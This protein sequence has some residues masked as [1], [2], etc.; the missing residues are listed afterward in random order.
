MNETIDMA[1]VSV[2]LAMP[3]HRG[4]EPGTLRPI[5]LTTCALKDRGIPF[6]VFMPAGG[7][8]V[9]HSR[10][11][12]VHDF[13]QS[14]RNRIFWVDSD[15]V[16]D[17]D[18]FIR[19]LAL[20]VEMEV[21]CGAYPAKREP[22]NFA[23]GPGTGHVVEANKYGC[24]PVNGVGI[25]FTCIQRHVIEQLADRAPKLKYPELDEPVAEVFRCDRVMYEPCDP[26]RKQGF[27][28]EVRGEDM[29]FFADILDLG[30]KIYLDPSI[31]LG[32]VGSK[33]YEGSIGQFL[34]AMTD[35]A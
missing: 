20:S 27:E 11:I 19:L 8:L 5:V 18:D 22:I 26:R 35:A 31:K 28:G 25:G 1:G 9:H 12:L 30:Y 7:S 32:H 34:A 16:W 23:L 2:M 21:V 14:N 10:S 29:A 33:T 24:I 6:S 15:I 4:I 13:L 3:V 17:A